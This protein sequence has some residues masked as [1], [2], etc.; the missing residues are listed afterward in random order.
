MNLFADRQE[1]DI[2]EHHREQ[3][4]TSQ[5][6]LRI[7]CQLTH[8]TKLLDELAKLAIELSHVEKG[9]VARRVRL[10][11]SPGTGDDGISH[12]QPGPGHR[13][14]THQTPARPDRARARVRRAARPS[15]SRLATPNQ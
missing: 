14:G 2:L 1:L 3:L 7:E 15:R 5:T 13:G 9:I 11:A 6:K 8:E 12:E 4:L 10:Y